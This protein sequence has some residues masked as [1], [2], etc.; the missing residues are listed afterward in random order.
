MGGDSLLGCGRSM[1]GQAGTS[2]GML[3]SPCR[4]SGWEVRQ[5]RTRRWGLGA[6][7]LL[8]TVAGSSEL[9]GN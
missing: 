2:T 1:P 5:S 8:R 3:A 9:G 7:S 6:V 4:E